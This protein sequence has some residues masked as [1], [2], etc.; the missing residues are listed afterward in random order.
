MLQFRVDENTSRGIAEGK[1]RVKG[2]AETEARD[3]PKVRARR[4]KAQVRVCQANLEDTRED[5]R[6]HRKAGYTRDSVGRAVERT[7]SR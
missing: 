7:Q 5:L 1:A 4:C 6:E 3:T 2:K